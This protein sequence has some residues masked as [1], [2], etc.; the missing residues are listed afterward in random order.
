VC[1]TIQLSNKSMFIIMTIY[2]RTPQNKRTHP[3]STHYMTTGVKRASP[4]LACREFIGKHNP[5][6]VRQRRRIVILSKVGSSSHS[7]ATKP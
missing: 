4:D 5:M 1:K 3:L 7:I 2:E 6:A